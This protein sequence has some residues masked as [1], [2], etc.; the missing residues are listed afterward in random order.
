MPNQTMIIR[1]SDPYRDE[2][3][4][5]NSWRGFF[6]DIISKNTF[7]VISEIISLQDM[8][9]PITTELTSVLDIT[10]VVSYFMSFHNNIEV[11][12]DIYSF[13]NLL[14]AIEKEIISIN[15]IATEFTVS[16]TSRN[17]IV[18]YTGPHINEIN[19]IN[20]IES[21]NPTY[22]FTEFNYSVIILVD[23]IIVSDS[24][25][26]WQI[27]INEDSYVNS[28]SIDFGDNYLFDLCNPISNFGNERIKIIIDDIMYQFL[29]E[30]RSFNENPRDYNFNVWGRSKTAKLDAPYAQ[31]IND[32]KVDYNEIESVWYSP[33]DNKYVPYVWQTRNTTAL[34]IMQAV[35]PGFTVQMD[36][37]DFIVKR[38]SF[39]VSNETPIEIINRLAKVVGAIVRT[40][41]DGDIIVRPKDFT[42][43]GTIVSSYTDL[44]HILILEEKFEFPDGYNRILVRG[45][46]DSDEDLEGTSALEENGSLFIELDNSL[47]N[48]KTTFEFGED[49]WFRV[50]KSPFTMSYTIDSSL[51][52]IYSVSPDV[53]E[54][55]MGELSS[56]SNFSLRTNKPINSL[57]HIKR[58]SG[59]SISLSNYN[60]NIGWQVIS[61]E[62]GIENEPVLVS[63]T[64]FYDLYKLVVEKPGTLTSEQ[65]IS[66]IRVEEIV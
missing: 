65:I 19:S 39:S 16:I 55:I 28:V 26:S 21:I 8:V 27:E 33:D 5:P 12:S 45:P 44:D 53:S 9:D 15:I 31:P 4:Y 43:D 57:I 37:E 1:Q 59:Q 56:F 24:V 48:D 14:E 30:R 52:T 20:R 11:S 29:L 54:T 38:K 17:D 32:K 7:E 3:L 35:S 47:N 13:N 60:F 25:V 36:I 42:T 40:N 10:S 61:S 66:R 46:K 34:E 51:G 23:D 41:L 64:S 6:V 63:Y 18:E 50:Y 62:S 49:A 2:R 58:Y 22:P